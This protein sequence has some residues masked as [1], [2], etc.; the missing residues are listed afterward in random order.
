MQRMFFIKN[1][2]FIFSVIFL[3]FGLFLAIY[4]NA[5]PIMQSRSLIKSMNVV[6]EGKNFD[7]AM[8]DFE[9]T[10]G[11]G[12]FGVREVREQLLNLTNAI[13][14]SKTNLTQEQVLRLVNLTKDEFKKETEE[15]LSP[16]HQILRA[17]ANQ[18]YYSLT[19]LGYQEALDEYQKALEI[20]P[21]YTRTYLVSF[22]FISTGITKKKP[23]KL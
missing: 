2:L 9:K 18:Q 4:L 6:A 15:Y 11:Y 23:S 8:E 1:V 16:K 5:G 3:A 20:A 10:L 22:S 12:G 19:R 7:K 17:G 14:S 21:K 13:V